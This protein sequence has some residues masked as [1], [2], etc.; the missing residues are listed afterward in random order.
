MRNSKVGKPQ[1]MALFRDIGPGP[2]NGY[3]SPM[4]DHMENSSSYV[5]I[6]E[7]V[8]I[9]FPQ[10]Q[11]EIVIDKYIAALD[12]SEREIRLEFQKKLDDIANQRSNLF[13]LTHKPT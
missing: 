6:S 8:E 11:D 13:A 10:L 9:T 5:R 4:G 7:Y 12:R 2:M 3:E 1:K